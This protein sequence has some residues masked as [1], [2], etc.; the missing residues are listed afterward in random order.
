MR[1]AARSQLGAGGSR[2]CSEGCA[3]AASFPLPPQKTHL[4]WVGFAAAFNAAGGRAGDPPPDPAPLFTP[5]T[6]KK[7]HVTTPSPAPP[8][9]QILGEP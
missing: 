2:L 5:P 7:H 4:D 9:P 6:V 8:R 3:E 1:R